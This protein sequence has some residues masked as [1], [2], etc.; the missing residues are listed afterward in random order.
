MV[1]FTSHQP[2]ALVRADGVAVD[3]QTYRLKGV[4]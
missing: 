3:V 4:S 2:V 1:L